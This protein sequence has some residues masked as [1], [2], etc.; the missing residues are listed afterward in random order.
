MSSVV[1]QELIN[2]FLNK[3]DKV[4]IIYEEL[5]KNKAVQSYLK[6]ANLMAVTRLK[7]NDHGVVHSRIVSGAALELHEILSK[8]V[9][10]SIIKDREGD[11]ED[12]KVVT[13]CAAY[14][15]D[16]GNAV[17]RVDHHFHGVI[18][19]NRL[20]DKIL[21]K[22]YKGHTRRALKIEILH[23]IFSHDENIPCLTLEAGIAKVADGLDMAEG[24]ARIPYKTGKVD[25]HALSALAIKKVE[26]EELNRYKK[27]IQIRIYMQSTAGVFQIEEVLMKKV[28]TSGIKEYLEIIGIKD[29]NVII[30][31]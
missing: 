15:H 29:K 7:Y 28:K 11:I 18:L 17:H 1:N 23:G 16:I 21:S 8:Y 27:F 30:K 19:A 22:V 24:R 6:L 2:K 9:Q 4:R 10:P 5:E 31:F 26:I 14:L 20:L 12:S 25:I 13:L 3:Y